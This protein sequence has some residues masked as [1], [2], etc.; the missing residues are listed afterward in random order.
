MVVKGKKV[1]QSDRR[2]S[3]EAIVIDLGSPRHDLAAPLLQNYTQRGGS[4]RVSVAE[5][6]F[7]NPLGRFENEIKLGENPSK[8]DKGRRRGRRRA[9]APDLYIP[10]PRLYQ[11]KP[12]SKKPAVK[13]RA[14]RSRVLSPSPSRARGGKRQ[15]RKTRRIVPNP[16]LYQAPPKRSLDHQTPLRCPNTWLPA[17]DTAPES[18]ASQIALQISKKIPFRELLPAAIKKPVVQLCDTQ[19][20]PH[21]TP[22][23]RIWEMVA[24]ISARPTKPALEKRTSFTLSTER[25]L[26]REKKQKVKPRTSKAKYKNGAPKERP[27]VHT[28]FLSEVGSIQQVRYSDI[29]TLDYTPPQSSTHV[30]P[31]SQK[32]RYTPPQSLT[33]VDTPLQKYRYPPPPLINHVETPSKQYQPQSEHFRLRTLDSNTS[34]VPP[35]AGLPIAASLSNA[36]RLPLVRPSRL[37]EAEMAASPHSTPEEVSDGNDSMSAPSEYLAEFL[38]SIMRRNYAEA[39]KYCRLIL[40]YE[41]N[42]TTAHG[43]YPLLK[44]K[45]GLSKRSHVTNAQGAS[46]DGKVVGSSYSDGSSSEAGAACRSETSPEGGEDVD[47]G[48]DSEAESLS[49]DSSGKSSRSASPAARDTDSSASECSLGMLGVTDVAVGPTWLADANGNPRTESKKHNKHSE[50]DDDENDNGPN[51]DH[52]LLLQET[53][54]R[55]LRAQFACSIK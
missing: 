28:H 46:N 37:P 51:G 26:V 44:H 40:H 47:K 55:Q 5:S 41:P 7:H 36:A 13:Q 6:Q 49:L 53:D 31:P 21:P 17:P 20:P 52:R 15:K 30:K 29:P 9:F 18:T 32:Y 1:L 3:D 8:T 24:S 45:L 43:F 22:R 12:A 39:L 33:H 42:N 23:D 34:T 10:N 35:A 2:L 11:S 27:G 48:S 4:T 19:L 14:Q 25:P 54:I 50:D 38:S 16:R